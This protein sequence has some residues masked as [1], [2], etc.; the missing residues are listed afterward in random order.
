MSSDQQ[1]MYNH[2]S[3]VVRLLSSDLPEE[4][5]IKQIGDIVREAVEI[6]RE[7]TINNVLLHVP[8]I[9]LSASTEFDHAYRTNST[10]RL[11]QISENDRQAKALGYPPLACGQCRNMPK[12]RGEFSALSHDAQPL[13]NDV[14]SG[15]MEAQVQEV[16]A[17]FKAHR[18]T[19]LPSEIEPRICGPNP[20]ICNFFHNIPL[21]IL[22]CL[23]EHPT[24]KRGGA[25]KSKAS[26]SYPRK[27]DTNREHLECR[28]KATEKKI[29]FDRFL[30]LGSGE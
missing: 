14:P 1:K 28:R 4:A 8:T 29:D 30:G 3:N 20:A 24:R 15:R 9:L 21:R 13:G 7:A 12:G 19:P 11:A 2:A 18:L 10:P 17:L 22:V 25:S 6:A 23:A 26:C 27:G 16:V 5:V